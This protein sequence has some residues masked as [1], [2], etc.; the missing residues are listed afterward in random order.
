MFFVINKVL[1]Q[2]VEIY[3]PINILAMCGHMI[4]SKPMKKSPVQKKAM[5]KTIIIA[6][7]AAGIF[8]IVCS[9]F[10]LFQNSRYFST[11]VAAAE[12]LK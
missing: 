6:T 4:Q 1:T 11:P 5:K 2:F 8:S 3:H 7:F 12:K 9:L 10:S